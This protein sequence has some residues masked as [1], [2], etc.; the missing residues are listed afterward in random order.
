MHDMG[1]RSGPAAPHSD[2]NCNWKEIEAWASI[3]TNTDVSMCILYLQVH[4]FVYICLHITVYVMTQVHVVSL[5][6]GVYIYI[7]CACVYA[8]ECLVIFFTCVMLP[9]TMCCRT[10][11]S[12][13]CV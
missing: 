11:T 4:T 7:M 5:C 13:L 3:W 9:W 10:F 12:A 1:M 2:R 6:V 8:H